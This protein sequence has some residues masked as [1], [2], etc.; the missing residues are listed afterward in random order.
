VLAAAR[1]EV[2]RTAQGDD[3]LA[4]RRGMP[5][6][7][8][9]DA[10]SWNDAWAVTSLL[11]RRSPWAPGSSSIDPS[12]KCEFSSSPVQIRTHR[13]IVLSLASRQYG[14]GRP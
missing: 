12:S 2:Q 3:Q 14:G 10:V 5:G 4:D 1:L 7:R 6:E 8:A 13:I 9:A 11:L